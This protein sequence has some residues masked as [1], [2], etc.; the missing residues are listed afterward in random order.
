MDSLNLEKIYKTFGIHRFFANPK[1]TT[2]FSK[3]T[4]KGIAFPKVKFNTIPTPLEP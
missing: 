1:S 3:E 2:Q 4:L